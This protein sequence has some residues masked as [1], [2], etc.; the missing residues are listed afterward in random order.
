MNLFAIYNC[1]SQKGKNKMLSNEKNTE[2]EDSETYRQK[3]L[4]I[5]KKHDER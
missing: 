1:Y 2:K 5:F 3:V 4:K